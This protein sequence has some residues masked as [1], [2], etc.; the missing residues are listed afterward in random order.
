MLGRVTLDASVAVSASFPAEAFFEDSHRLLELLVQDQTMIVEP[1]L[2]RPEIAAAVRRS[3]GNPEEAKALEETFAALPGVVFKDLDDRAADMAVEIAATA[4]LRGADAVYATIA[5]QFD[6]T[7]I[8]LDS[9]QRTRLPADI[10]A[11][12]PS[13]AL[14]AM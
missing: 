6:A 9:E 5:R 14:E 2:I 7:L 3:T 13:E 10:I 11:L 12:Y 1:S 8:T 4:G